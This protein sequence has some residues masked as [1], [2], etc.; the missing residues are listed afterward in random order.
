MINRDMRTMTVSNLFLLPLLKIGRDRLMKYQLINTYLFNAENDTE[1]V[2]P[3]YLLF[4][5]ESMEAF[6]DFLDDQREKG[7]PILNEEDYPEGLV[8]VT[9]QLPAEFEEDY[10]KIWKGKYSSTSEKYKTLVPSLVQ[11]RENGVPKKQ[12]SIQHMIMNKY[13]PLKEFWEDEFGTVLDDDQELWA[14]PTREKETFKL[15][16]HVKPVATG[17]TS[18]TQ[19]E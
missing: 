17:T 10:K 4:Q 2:N 19:R 12:M 8:V 18:T 15:S 16:E 1:Y 5:P 9:Y 13:A 3:I 14:K 6:N 11:W 7:Y